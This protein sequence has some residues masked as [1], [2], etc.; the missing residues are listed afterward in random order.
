MKANDQ[1]NNSTST[2]VKPLCGIC[3]A[4]MVIASLAMASEA[5][6]FSGNWTLN[7][8]KSNFGNSEFRNAANTLKITQ[9]AAKIIIER[10][11]AR[12]NGE[13]YTYSETITLDGKEC[14]NTINQDRKRKSTANLSAD[15]K[16]LT[17]TSSS[18]MERNGQ[19]FEMK[20]SEI[21]TLADKV[22]MV[23]V[24]SSSPRGEMKNK[25][26]YDKK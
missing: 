22:L 6:N 12:R 3:F 24:T 15:G 10:S 11:G 17:I 14:E 5:T 18:S 1:F 19:T 13:T 2:W 8:E 23:D 21:Y 16:S 26:V 4:L 7:N 25:L 9:D 20:S